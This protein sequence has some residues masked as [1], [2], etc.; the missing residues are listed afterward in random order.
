[1]STFAFLQIFFTRNYIFLR[2]FYYNSVR[3][4]KNSIY[5]HVLSFYFSAF[6]L[7]AGESYIATSRKGHFQDG[8]IQILEYK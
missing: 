5:D 3:L 4:Y 8:F 7:Y 6:F 1:M 2:F